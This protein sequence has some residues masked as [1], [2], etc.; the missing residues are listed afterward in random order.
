MLLLKSRTVVWLLLPFNFVCEETE[1]LGDAVEG[2]AP[3]P[4]IRESQKQGPALVLPTSDSM[5]FDAR[6]PVCLAVLCCVLGVFKYQRFVDI[7]CIF[8]LA[9][10]MWID[11]I[12]EFG[13]MTRSH[14]FKESWRQCTFTSLMIL[15]NSPI[16]PLLWESHRFQAAS[17]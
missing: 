15:W 3:R 6:P 9:W 16:T 8:C 1:A 12:L 13:G 11:A 7:I 17:L 4:S 2:F 5:S 14:S 10:D